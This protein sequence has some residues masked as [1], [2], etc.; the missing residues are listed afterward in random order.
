MVRSADFCCG[1]GG[2]GGVGGDGINPTADNLSEAVG[3]TG[4]CGVV[5]LRVREE[6]QG[7]MLFFR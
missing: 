1:A 2:A 6:P 3:D 5:I 7:L 4:G